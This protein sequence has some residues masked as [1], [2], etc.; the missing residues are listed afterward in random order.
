MTRRSQSSARDRPTRRSWN[1]TSPSPRDKHWTEDSAVERCSRRM[2]RQTDVYPFTRAAFTIF[3]TGSSI[4]PF[5][6]PSPLVGERGAA[7]IAFDHVHPLDHHAERREARFGR[8]GVEGGDVGGQDEEVAA[9]GLAAGIGHDDRP[10]LVLAGRWSLVLSIAIGGNCLAPSRDPALDQP[11]VGRAAS[12]DR[13]AGRR[14]SP[15]RHRQGNWRWSAARGRGRARPRSAPSRSRSRPGRDRP[16]AAGS[17]RRWRGLR[18]GR[19]GDGREQGGEDDL[20]GHEA[21]ILSTAK[22]N[23]RIHSLSPSGRNPL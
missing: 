7:K 16:S 23:P 12:R 14:D 2:S 15:C 21:H 18:Q 13:M 20:V 6:A 22:L 1:I 4:W 11:A 3:T 10:G 17:G 8:G 5:I 19:S 9:R